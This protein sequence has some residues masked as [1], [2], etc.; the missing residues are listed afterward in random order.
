MNKRWKGSQALL[1]VATALIIGGIINGRTFLLVAPGLIVGT[2]ALMVAIMKLRDRFVEA[3]RPPGV[4]NT[5][6]AFLCLSDSH[7]SPTAASSLSSIEM[8]GR[9]R[10]L[11]RLNEIAGYLDIRPNALSWRPAKHLETK[12][13]LVGM[14]LEV[15]QISEARLTP[16]FPALKGILPKA[17]LN[18]ALEDGGRL[19]FV[20]RDYR[21]L[22]EA[23]DQAGIDGSESD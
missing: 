7:V 6:T 12:H 13:K 2:A 16:E 21:R 22:K 20:I 10:R 14:E 15:N 17:T 9:L 8:M 23:L 18:V 19:E 11:V 5:F 1:L 3:N 4:I